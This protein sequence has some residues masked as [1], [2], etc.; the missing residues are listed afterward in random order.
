MKIHQLMK[1]RQ[2]MEPETRV[3]KRNYIYCQKNKK[4]EMDS[5]MVSPFSLLREI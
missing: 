4:A 1:I 3:K 2:L 5:P